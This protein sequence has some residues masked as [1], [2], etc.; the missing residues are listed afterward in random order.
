MK[1]YLIITPV[2]CA[3]LNSAL[4]KNSDPK[5]K[6]YNEADVY[7]D[8]NYFPPKRKNSKKDLVYYQPKSGTKLAY[9]YAM[10]KGLIITNVYRIYEEFLN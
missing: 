6:Q 10:K 5:V 3:C 9:D 2:V 1:K 8:E 4:A 7:Y